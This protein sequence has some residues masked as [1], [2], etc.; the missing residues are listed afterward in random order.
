MSLPEIFRKGIKDKKNMLQPLS[1][2]VKPQRH[3]EEKLQGGLSIAKG[4]V[5]P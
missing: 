2:W 1:S 5:A 4:I 3:P